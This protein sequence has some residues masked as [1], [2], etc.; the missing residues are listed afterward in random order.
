M[1][2]AN[3]IF[4]KAVHPYGDAAKGKNSKIPMLSAIAVE[5]GLR[6]GDETYLAA[7]VEIKPDVKVEV[8]DGVAQVLKEF[9]DIMPPELPKTLPPRREIDH[10]IELLPGS[11]APAQA[12][13]RMAPKELAE[14]RR[15][16]NE[17][18]EAGLIQPS[19][20]PYGA[21]VLFQKKQDGSLRMCVDYRALN[22][23]TVKNKYPVPLV[24]DLMD[25]LSKASWFT[26]LDLRS[27]YWQVSR[28]VEM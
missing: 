22:K 21:P 1:N 7:L 24:Q 6:K 15:Q 23:V 25:R 26:K 14:L 19:K 9:A 8:P 20:A 17:L 13:Y 16:L 12:P 4:L 5:K 10:K 27:G 28:L 3:P 18:L 11:V 2:E